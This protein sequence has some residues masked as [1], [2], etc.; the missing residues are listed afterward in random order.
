MRVCLTCS[1]YSFQNSLKTSGHRGYELMEFWCWNL[2]PFF[3]KVCT[4]A[5]PYHQ[6]RWLFNWTL[7]THG[8]VFLLFSP[9]DTA[10]V[11]SNKNVKFGLLELIEHFYTLKQSILNEPWP[12]GHDSASGP[13]S[14]M[15]LFLY[16]IA[17][18]GICRWHGRLCLPTVVSGSI[19]G[20]I[21][22]CPCQWQNHADEWCSVIGGPEDH[23]H[24]TKIFSLVPYA[25]RFLQF[26]WIFWW[27]FQ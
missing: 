2:I 19:P 24:P 10:S 4:Y 20:P 8:K 27:C 1:I 5:P 11:I 9:E 23:G 21:G 22:F 7:I 18:V 16:A 14:H 17:L 3:I 26:L 13:C 25:Q 12:T 6:R 15:V